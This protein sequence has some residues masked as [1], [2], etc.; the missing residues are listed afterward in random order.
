LQFPPLFLSQVGVSAAVSAISVS[1]SESVSSVSVVSVSGPLA[2]L[3]GNVVGGSGSD[4]RGEWGGHGTSP[5]VGNKTSELGGQAGGGGGG[6]GIGVTAIS[7]VC[8]GLGLGVTLAQTV[9]K[10]SNTVDAKG[11]GGSSHNGGGSHNWGSSIAKTSI[12]ETVSSVETAKAVAISQPWLSLGLGLG[13]ALPQVSG[14]GKAVT[15]VESAGG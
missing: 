2:V 13:V 5:G 4:G 10:G 9:S 1:K 15:S 8:L 11:D 14:Q 7:K 12:A 3:G 6:V